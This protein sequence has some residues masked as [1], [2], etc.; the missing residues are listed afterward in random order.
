MDDALFERLDQA[1]HRSRCRTGFAIAPGIVTNNLDADRARARAGAH[2]VHPGDG[3]V[4]A[5]AVGRRRLR[6]AA[7]SGFRRSTTRCWSPS[8][9]TIRARPTSSAACG[10]R[11]D[12]PP[13]DAADRLPD[14]AR[15]QDRA[16]RRPRP[17]DRVR[18][19]AAVDHDH[20]QHEAED[21][22]RSAEDQDQRTPPARCRSRS[23]TR[24]RR[25]RSSRR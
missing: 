2:P 9:R 18:R 15:D 19:R 11:R 8:P 1:R 14:Q 22:D 24:R 20:Q 23:T 12:R 5:R 4:G 13:L 17:R 25:S 21:H 3:A 10:A 16:R 7:S 6:A